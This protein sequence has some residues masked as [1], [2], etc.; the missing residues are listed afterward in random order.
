MPDAAVTGNAFYAGT[1]HALRA[2]TEGLRQEASSSYDSLM[3]SIC[4]TP[5][6]L[7]AQLELSSIDN[8]N[9]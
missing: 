9:G 6:M 7:R 3:P 8:W 4:D 2:L 1:K 5:R